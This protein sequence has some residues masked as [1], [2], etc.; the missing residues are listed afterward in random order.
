VRKPH[1]PKTKNENSTMTG[2]ER[3]EVWN[4]AMDL[5]VDVYDLVRSL[6]KE[7]RYA[8]SDQMRRC[9]VSIPSNIAEGAS[10]G[11][12]KEFIQFLYIAMGSASELQTQLEIGRRVGYFEDVSQC[13]RTIISIR[14]MI[15]ALITSIKRTLG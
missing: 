15:N 5:V 3:L 13:S 12:K 6:P 4:R 7:E 10:R 1:I 9:A 8:L 14:K 2:Y 11:S